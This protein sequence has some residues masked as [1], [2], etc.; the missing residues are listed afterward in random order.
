MTIS[1]F[2]TTTLGSAAAAVV[3][4]LAPKGGIEKLHVPDDASW[5]AARSRDVTASV[6]A[7]LFGAHEYETPLS[8]F[9]RK[10]GQSTNDLEDS[11]PIRRGRLLESVAVQ[12]LREEN[13]N[14]MIRYNNGDNR[15]YYRDAKSRLGCTPDVEVYDPERGPGIVQIKSVE[16]SIYRRKWLNDDREPDPPLWIAVQAVIEATL[17]GSEWAAVA[18]IVVGHGV[19]MP[20]IDVPLHAGMMQ[21]LRTKVAEFWQ[22]VADGRPYDP[23]FAKDG[24][25]IAGLYADDDDST[26]DLSGD[27]RI[28]EILAAREKLKEREADGAAATKERKP[29]DAEIINILGNAARGRLSDGRIVEAKTVRRKGFT[30]EPMQF[31]SVKVKEFSNVKRSTSNRGTRT[32]QAASADPFG[33]AF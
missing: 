17:T 23:D 31:R 32:Q 12:V 9:M 8:L 29:L 28:I 16:A 3:E 24:A 26:K 27:N 30:V 10:T 11:G 13:P 5:H 4:K 19:E 6:A 2:E 25:L 33:A 22:R 1:T 18:P 15:Y 7:A 20:L 21:Q 14:W